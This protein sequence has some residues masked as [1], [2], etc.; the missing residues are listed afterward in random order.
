MKKIMTAI[1]T[2]F[3]VIALV[4]CGTTKQSTESKESK[5]T[6]SAAASLTESLNDLKE[7]Y[8]KQSS[9][10]V[11]FNFASSGQLQKQI[12]QGAPVDVFISASKD[13]M[14]KLQQKDLIDKDSREDF[15]KNNLVLIVSK[16]FK[17]KIKNIDDLK[18]ISS[19]DKVA[20][21]EPESV[22]AGK[23]GKQ[24]LKYYNLYD[25]LKDNLVFGKNV[26]QVAQFVENGE[27]VAGIVFESDSTVLKESYVAEIIEDKAHKPIVYPVAIINNSKNKE[28]AK[29][30]I[31][32]L[33]SGKGQKAF[34][35]HKFV[36]IKEADK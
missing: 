29:E 16:E 2:S 10:T 24:T 31:K 17:D 14:D 22:P 27:A 4:G 13:K 23:Y 33:K 20:M 26:K 1:I 18:N 30:F 35:S 34:K 32:Y 21:G 12:E 11:N 19:K 8:E 7:G 36:P 6:V 5:L 15:L 3:M 25:K 28:A 9:S